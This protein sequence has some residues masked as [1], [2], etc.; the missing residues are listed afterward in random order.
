MSIAK[1]PE[2][3]RRPRSLSLSD[4]EM[5]RSQAAARSAGLPWVDFVRD[6]I[7]TACKRVEGKELRAADLGRGGR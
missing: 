6:A 2:E 4:Q 3:R 5:G 7:A 1:R